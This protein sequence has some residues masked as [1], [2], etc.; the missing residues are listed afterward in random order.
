MQRSLIFRFWLAV[1]GIF[2]AVAIAGTAVYVWTAVNSEISQARDEVAVREESLKV[3]SAMAVRVL[4]S[5]G[6]FIF[7][8]ADFAMLRNL[9]ISSFELYDEN[10]VQILDINPY[11]ESIQITPG[12]LAYIRTFEAGRERLASGEPMTLPPRTTLVPS[13]PGE[14]ISAEQ[15]A[16]VKAMGSTRRVMSI[17]KDGRFT[18]A[19]NKFS[20]LAVISGQRFGEELWLD[21]G[22]QAHR[23]YFAMTDLTDDVRTLMLN[24]V[25]VVLAIF[26]ATSAGCWVLLKQLIFRPLTHYSGIATL[27][28]NGEPLRMPT[29][30][31]GEMVGLA[32]AVNEMA[33]AL[34]SRA[35]IDSLT[36]L[37]NHRHMTEEMSRLLGLAQHTEKPLSV[38]V[39]DLD[40]FKLIN[41]SFGHHAGDY[42]LSEVAKILHEWAGGEYICWRLGG[43]EF[44]AAMPGTDKGR[45]RI[46]AARLQRM[47]EARSFTVTGGTVRTTVSMGVASAPADGDTAGD[48]MN[49]ADSKMYLRKD[50]RNRPEAEP[51]T[52]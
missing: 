1:N 48:L 35:T 10:G 17:S 45:A 26:V 13:L 2:L 29:S 37:Y 30:G 42:V 22:A 40:S 51:R 33:D 46:E 14:R 44:A 20:P 43:D 32:R 23:S 8:D 11:S 12:Y 7:S 25:L 16:N 15:L 19:E 38:L 28:A 50:S 18:P 49:I 52:A 9:D 41:D 24:A 36:G 4:E 6:T 21:R 34:E 3:F 31:H 5:E 39:A 47:I 27:I